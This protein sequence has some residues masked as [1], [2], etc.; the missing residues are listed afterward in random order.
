MALSPRTQ[1]LLRKQA[2]KANARAVRE[3]NFQRSEAAKANRRALM[4][5]DKRARD[6]RREKILWI[7]G[8]VGVLALVGGCAAIA[9]VSGGAPSDQNVPG[10]TVGWN[11]SQSEADDCQSQWH[12]A[13]GE[14]YRTSL[15]GRASSDA[16]AGFIEVC[17]R[18]DSYNGGN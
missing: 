10:Y 16:K 18:T 12:S 3:R 5:P 6:I 1:R 15:A 17:Y 11:V 9:V 14:A 2:A 4:T 13:P 7:G 8:L